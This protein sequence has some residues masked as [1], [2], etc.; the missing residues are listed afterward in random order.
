MTA[1]G[2][3]PESIN[4]CDFEDLEQIVKALSRVR[5]SML[6]SNPEKTGRFFICGQSGEVDE[7]GLPDHLHVCPTY[8]LDKFE[9]YTRTKD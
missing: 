5:M 9:I 1:L 8:G 4:D 3:D 7:Q 6:T 2:Y